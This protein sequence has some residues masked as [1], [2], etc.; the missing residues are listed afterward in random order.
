MSHDHTSDVA[1]LVTQE[2]WDAR[3]RSADQIWGGKPN[4]QLVEQVADLGPSTALDVGC[5][6]DA[7]AIWLASRGWH[8]TAIDLSTVALDR[9][10]ERV[11][12][13]GAEVA[14]RIIWQ[15]ADVRS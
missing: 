4:R 13:A 7:D 8:V 3:Y 14:D 2:L 9:A 10:A 12:Q 11:A 5:G 1:A 6:E 15:Q